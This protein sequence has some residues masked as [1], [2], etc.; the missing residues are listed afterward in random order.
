MANY[1]ARNSGKVVSYQPFGVGNG[2]SYIHRASNNKN[3]VK[4]IT[5]AYDTTYKLLARTGTG[6]NDVEWQSMVKEDIPNK[7]DAKNVFTLLNQL[8]NIVHGYG[9]GSYKYMTGGFEPGGSY[10]R[11]LQI[12]NDQRAVIGETSVTFTFDD[13]RITYIHS[14]KVIT[15]GI[16]ATNPINTDGAYTSLREQINAYEGKLLF[17][18]CHNCH[19]LDYY[20]DG[21][22]METYTGPV[23]MGTCGI[24]GESDK[25]SE[26]FYFTLTTDGST[27]GYYNTVC[28]SP[29]GWDSGIGTS[30]F[31]Y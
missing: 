31:Y 21:E 1:L 9:L 20:E 6:R 3:D 27:S 24:S 2:Y 7:K 5:P 8:I 29:Q 23:Y 15:F 25:F 17:R 26:F 28:L 13:S 10:H 14:H 30:T 11:Y 4:W 22:A 18:S 12:P 16:H 19:I